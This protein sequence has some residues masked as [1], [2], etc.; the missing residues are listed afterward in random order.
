MPQVS[1]SFLEIYGED[2]FDLLEDSDA[3][4]K[5]VSLPVREEGGNIVVVGLRQLEV[6]S[7]HDA[8]QVLRKGSMN[9]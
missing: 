5:Q 2:I 6:K 1:A 9:R 7:R 4:T 8:M 3:P